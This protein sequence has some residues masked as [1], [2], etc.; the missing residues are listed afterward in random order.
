VRARLLDGLRAL[1]LPGLDAGL[2]DGPVEAGDV[3]WSV[4]LHR[5]VAPKGAAR[6]IRVEL[7]W[8]RA[9]A[10]AADRPK[11]RKPRPLAPPAELPRWLGSVARPSSTRR[12]VG[13]GV[14]RTAKRTTVTLRLLFHNGYAQDELIGRVTRIAAAHGLVRAE[15]DGLAQVWRGSNG[16]ELRFEPDPNDLRLGCYLA[17]PVLTIRFGG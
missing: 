4:R 16:R 3:R 2:P 8:R 11:C 6:E 15:G 7:A 5:L 12:L 13:A 9:P 17:G 14:Q 1:K 10:P